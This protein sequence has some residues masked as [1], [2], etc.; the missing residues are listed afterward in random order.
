MTTED[1]GPSPRP[2]SLLDGLR[3]VDLSLWQP[4]HTASQL[5]ADLGADVVK[6][7]PPGGD[8]MRPLVDRFAN[9]NGRKRSVVLD[10]KD[11]GDRDALLRLVA[12]AEVVIENYRPGVAERLGVGFEALR[13]ANPAI[14]MCSI[15]GFGQDGPLASMTGH[16][17][18]YQA[19]AGAFTVGD[20]G[21]PSA[22]GLLVGDQGSGLAA[23][24]AILA[25][26][27][28]ARRTGEAEH[29]DVSVADLLATWVAPMGPVDDRRQPR[30]APA[31]GTAPAMGNFI[32][33]DG[34]WVV[35]GVFS[36]DHFWDGLCRLLG[37]H[38]LVGLSMA[39]RADRADRLRGEIADAVARWDRDDLVDQLGAAAV[40]IAPVLSREE[41][42]DHAHFRARGVI[43]TGPDGYRSVGHPI[44]FR[45]HPALPPGRAP[46]L[47][48]HRSELLGSG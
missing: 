24:F 1:R 42:L 43:T 16:D 5:L 18:N 37:R 11:D 15:S 26:V 2:G 35:L 33:A 27:L 45:L 29:I 31:G 25:A 34:R 36:E 44:R 40:P 6:I 8:R 7:E 17:A 30:A 21:K 13:A 9:F 41:M 20:G 46:A 47:D 19:Y 39:E 3:V 38:D 28:F 48:E 22:S 32:T 12:A 14:V 23:A 10:L 4:G